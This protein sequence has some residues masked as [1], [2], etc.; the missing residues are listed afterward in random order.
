M[1]I[2]YVETQTQ[3][4]ESIVL[5]MGEFAVTNSPDA[6][7]SCIGLGSCIAICMYDNLA[8]VG[9]MAHVV[10]PRHD[11]SAN[12]NLG[13]YANTAVPHLLKQVVKAGGA[14]ERL[15]IKVAGGAQMSVMAGLRDAFKTGEKN[16]AEVQ[17]ALEQERIK[18]AA[19]DVGGNMG[20]T[21]K[22]YI[23][24]GK[25]IVKTV[26]GIVKEL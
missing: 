23:S 9:G 10:L 25:V 19:A 15:I 21:V 20:R 8:K 1:S 16:L 11:G 7:L 22:M 17:I 2:S 18:L 6:V 24:T 5:G 13:R 14:R 12:V 26:D 4:G 3:E